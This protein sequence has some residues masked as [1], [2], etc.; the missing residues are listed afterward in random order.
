MR[1]VNRR[2]LAS[3]PIDVD[4][5]DD[6]GVPMKAYSPGSRANKLISIP[7]TASSID[8]ETSTNTLRRRVKSATVEAASVIETV[9]LWPFPGKK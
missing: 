7:L 9:S 8:N 1:R 3:V 2:R 5:D 6:H 4:S